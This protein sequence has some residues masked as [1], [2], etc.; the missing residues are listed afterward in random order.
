MARHL[1]LNLPKRPLTKNIS[2]G[3]GIWWTPNRAFIDELATFLRGKRV[4]EVFAGS[5]YLAAEMAASGVDI[6]AT[7]IFSGHDNHAMGL[8]HPV[9]E[10][11]AETAVV[12]RGD[13]R[14]VLLFCWP[15]VTN[16]VLHAS[17][18]WG[19]DRDIVFIGEMP[20]P[21]W[22]MGGLAGCATDEFFEAIEITH[23][24]EKYAGNALE[25]AVVCRIR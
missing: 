5:G 19:T 3:D 20:K 7:T 14:D 12:T 10:M 2:R 22:G 21:S 1:P 17:L 8:F 6:L 4:L 15:T 24:F 23:R 11:S 25:A 13:G 9:E 16:A 18:L